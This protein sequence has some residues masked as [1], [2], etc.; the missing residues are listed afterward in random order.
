MKHSVVDDH[1]QNMSNHILVPDSG[2]FAHLIQPP[3]CDRLQEDDEDDVLDAA[4][5]RSCLSSDPEMQS[6]SSMAAT[7]HPCT[8]VGPV[9][10]RRRG[11][12]VHDD[13]ALLGDDERR[14]GQVSVV[15]QKKT[16]TT[17]INL[18]LNRQDIKASTASPAVSILNNTCKVIP[19]PA[20]N[21]AAVTAEKLLPPQDIG[22]VFSFGDSEIGTISIP[23]AVENVQVVREPQTVTFVNVKSSE[24]RERYGKRYDDNDDDAKY[25]FAYEVRD[26]YTCN[27]QARE[28]W[29]DGKIVKGVYRV[30]DPDGLIRIVTYGDDGNGFYANV[31]RVPQELF[32]KKCFEQQQQQVRTGYGAPKRI[33]VG[34]GGGRSE[35]SSNEN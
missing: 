23:A 27:Y 13:L 30:V 34:G 31:E 21:E 16:S 19:D 26:D 29:R 32:D 20:H 33:R 10:R 7:P 4:L 35:S 18:L 6:R 5:C 17:P 2:E 25:H 9:K 3:L 12:D 11:V 22:E 8:V 24:S 1:F 15:L 14:D 28:E